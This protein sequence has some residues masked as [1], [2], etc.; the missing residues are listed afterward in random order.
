MNF[1][2]LQLLEDPSA[3]LEADNALSAFAQQYWPEQKV[4]NTEIVLN[5]VRMLVATA[6]EGHAANQQTLLVSGVSR[7]LAE[8]SLASNAPPQLKA[9]ALI[10]LSDI[11]RG[12]PANQDMFT[13]LWV[14]PLIP[15]F[16]ETYDGE[17]P[18]PDEE[19][20]WQRA[21]PVPA[22]LALI[23]LAVQGD[24]ALGM[25]AASP[26]GLRVRTAAVSL[27]EVSFGYLF[28]YTGPK[29]LITML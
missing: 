9:A 21:Q 8:L 1:P 2:P 22:I 12:S 14:Q 23:A 26:S 17:E 4:A 5:L 3:G 25:E 6:G 20:D 16:P 10:T 24:P 19:P 27:F 13:N 7:C 11:F 29:L 18:S 28:S 15:V